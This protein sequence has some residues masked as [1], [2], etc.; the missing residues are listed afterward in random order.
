MLRLPSVCHG[1]GQV[2]WLLL[3]CACGGHRTEVKRPAYQV[4]RPTAADGGAVPSPDHDASADPPQD[5]FTQCEPLTRETEGSVNSNIESPADFDLGF[6]AVNRDEACRTVEIIM[7]D[8]RCG[9]DNGHRLR[10]TFAREALI[11]GGFARGAVDVSAAEGRGELRLLYERPEAKAPAGT[12]G[13]CNRT[14]GTLNLTRG[15][16]LTPGAPYTATFQLTL[17]PCA[18]TLANPQDVVG[19]FAT[20]LPSSVCTDPP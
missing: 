6:V 16:Q 13:S 8:G 9:R 10:F 18:G 1:R 5:V 20:T 3:T 7:G 19:S 14:E 15:A 2:F 4:Q 11:T 12:F 17:H